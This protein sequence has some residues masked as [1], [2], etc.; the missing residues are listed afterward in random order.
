MKDSE[1]NV[2]LGK[3]DATV[4][5]ALAKEYG[6]EGFPTIILFHKGFKAEDYSGERTARGME[7]FSSL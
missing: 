2:T 3:V 1:L 6:I 4:E 7:T 5:T